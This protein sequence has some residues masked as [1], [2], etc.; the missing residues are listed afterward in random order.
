VDIEQGEPW[1]I[2]DLMPGVRAV[3]F[4]QPV[5]FES[6]DGAALRGLWDRLLEDGDTG[7]IVILNFQPVLCLDSGF[8]AGLVRAWKEL[9]QRGGRLI[10]CHLCDDLIQVL[11]VSSP[12]QPLDYMLNYVVSE[13][14]A[15]EKA[16]LLRGGT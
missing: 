5:L 11:R 7:P 12:S 6:R 4:T 14:E 9:S 10:S 8:L 16:R 3:R 13:A 1:V 2:V 15:V